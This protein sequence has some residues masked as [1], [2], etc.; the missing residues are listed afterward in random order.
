LL[1]EQNQKLIQVVN[2][3]NKKIQEQESTNSLLKGEIHNLF[4]Q[5]ES[6]ANQQVKLIYQKEIE[7]L[8]NK[9]KE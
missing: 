8:K 1:I 7:F 9:I 5:L 2:G 4:N 6:H 3:D